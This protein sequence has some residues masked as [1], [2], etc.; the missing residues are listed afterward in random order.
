MSS[1]FSAGIRVSGRKE[2]DSCRERGGMSCGKAR[3]GN[4]LTGAV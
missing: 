4:I 1:P 3:I 2:A